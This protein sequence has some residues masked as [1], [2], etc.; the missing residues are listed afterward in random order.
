MGRRPGVKLH[1]ALEQFERKQLLSGAA[2]TVHAGATAVH[3][4]TSSAAAFLL[5]R[6]TN[7]THNN[8]VLRPPFQQVLVQG[9]QPVPGQV[10]NILSVSV[11]N[12]TGRTFDASSGFAVRVTGQTGSFPILTG[13]EVWRP[14]QAIVFYV[15]TKK[16]Y[17][18]SPVVGAGFEFDFAGSRGV[19]IP[20]PSGIFL[21]LTYNP[22]TFARTLNHIIVHG[23]GAKGHRL[24]LP[25][26]SIWEF[27][28]AKNHM[29]PL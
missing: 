17:P 2:P 23:P 13:N 7:P 25:D 26:T 12:G 14:R 3:D 16:Y 15:L 20:G 18:L 11:K 22:T 28:S 5:F 4:Q 19:A 1:P 9:T 24:G 6:I 29:V 8:G 21:R 27:T 10:Y